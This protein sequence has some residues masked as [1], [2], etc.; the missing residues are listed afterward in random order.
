MK[1]REPCDI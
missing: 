1:G